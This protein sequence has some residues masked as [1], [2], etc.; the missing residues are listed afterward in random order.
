MKI[1]ISNLHTTYL[2]LLLTLFLYL[3]TLRNGVVWDDR[4]ALLNNPDAL[5]IRPVFAAF[6]HDFWGQEIGRDDSHKS[7]RPISVLTYRINHYFH[8]VQPMGYHFVNVLL[9]CCAQLL[10]SCLARGIF[11]GEKAGGMKTVV[12]SWLFAV[13][14]I[15]TEPVCCI[16]GRSDLLCTVFYLLALIFYVGAERQTSTT[17]YRFCRLLCAYTLGLLSSLSKEVGLMIFPGES[18]RIPMI[19]RSLCLSAETMSLSPDRSTTCINIK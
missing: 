6:R 3:P 9:H 2:P 18:A 14:P 17:V 10:F 4:A 13:H 7:Y 16:V 1:I 11:E 12:S 8:G 19:S 15:H 5:G